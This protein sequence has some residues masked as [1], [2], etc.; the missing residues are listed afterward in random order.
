MPIRSSLA[1]RTILFTLVVGLLAGCG[2]PSP[3]K[4]SSNKPRSDKKAPVDPPNSYPEWTYDAPQSM[5]PAA[6]LTPEPRARETDPLHYFTNK[7]QVPIR[8]PGGYK[9]EEIPR[10]AVW[11]TDNNGFEWKK[12]GYFGQSQSYFWFDAPSDGDYGVRFV[13]PGQEPAEIP[14]AEPVRVYH[15]DTAPPAV[16]LIVDPN[17]A[18]YRPGQSIALHW[19]AQDAHLVE[20]PVEIGVATD[21]SSDQPSW[22]V[23]QKDLD[24][25]GSYTYT[26]PAD[27][28]GRGL[29][30]RASARDRAGNLG[31]GFSHLIQVQ[32]EP[33]IGDRV[34][35]P[36][37]QQ[38]AG[39]P[40][41]GAG[42]QSP[43]SVA[44]TVVDVKPVSAAAD[45]PAIETLQPAPL[46]WTPMDAESGTASTPVAGQAAPVGE[47]KSLSSEPIA[48]PSPPTDVRFEEV[49]AAGSVQRSS[50]NP[51]L[52]VL[53]DRGSPAR[54]VGET[55]PARVD[56]IRPP[57]IQSAEVSEV[58]AASPGP[59]QPPP[60]PPAAN[61]MPTQPLVIE[62]SAPAVP[63]SFGSD[64]SRRPAVESR[65]SLAP[66]KPAPSGGLVAPLPGTAPNAASPADDRPWQ[67]LKQPTDRKNESVWALPKP[68]FLNDLQ[69]L[70]ERQMLTQN[71]DLMPAAPGADT[72]RPVADAD[73]TPRDSREPIAP[74]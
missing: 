16:E 30:F 10:V 20:Q 42:G 4:L 7:K 18:W 59:S 35:G 64:G 19:K 63:A 41:G 74:K 12:A 52:D 45:F 22:T 31:L 25:S 24:A 43:G 50:A 33:N 5:K 3:F 66:S 49:P 69:G 29:T 48:P 36:N 61:P 44:S 56:P 60:A 27:A 26:I 71:P 34:A 67:T 13:G 15:I 51:D 68:A 72:A 58:T 14:V 65:P 32:D 39:A 70:F 23:L 46:G 17:Q 57:V 2:K 11:Y 54:T 6:D 9:P 1:G 40:S 53:F 8:Q 47:A 21:F 37:V 62:S 73:V 38:T 55:M 28:S